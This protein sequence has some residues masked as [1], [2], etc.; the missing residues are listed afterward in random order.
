MSP[1]DEMSAG[2]ETL[3]DYDATNLTA[4]PHLLT[5]FR[6][7]LKRDG[8]YSAIELKKLANGKRV[9]RTGA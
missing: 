3:A 2:E 5:H 7:Q 9:V 8:V 4:G 1:L 6:P